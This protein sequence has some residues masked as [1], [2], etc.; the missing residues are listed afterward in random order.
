MSRTNIELD[1]KLV[2]ELGKLTKIKTKKELVDVALRE[3][4][5]QYNRKKLLSL[6]GKGIW[7]GDLDEW[8]KGR[9]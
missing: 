5:N 7:D 1:D 8:R 4:F 3:L 2:S 9:F 6:T